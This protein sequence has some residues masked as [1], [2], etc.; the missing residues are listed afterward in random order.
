HDFPDPENGPAEC[1]GGTWEPNSGVCTFFSRGNY[2]A[3]N[4]FD[5]N[6]GFGNPTNGDIANQAAGALDASACPR[7]NTACTPTANPDPNCFSGNT[8]TSSTSEWPAELQESPCPP[9]SS[10]SAVLTAQLLCATGATS[11]FTQGSGVTPPNCTAPGANY[12]QRNATAQTCPSPTVPTPA[13]GDPSAAVCFLPL[14]YTVSPRV[15]PPMPDPCAGVPANAWCA[16]A[17]ATPELPQAALPVAA[18][19]IA[20]AAFLLIGRVQGRR[21]RM[22]A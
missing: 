15:S 1:Q 16:N 2:V 9:G 7:G 14:S 10:E 18:G 8:L 21:R 12:P 20:L 11:L 5:H 4:T 6:G 3:N 19:G 17:V 22:R 13:N